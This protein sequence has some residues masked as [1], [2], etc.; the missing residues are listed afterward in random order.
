MILWKDADEYALG[1]SDK[2]RITLSAYRMVDGKAE[3]C[4][5]IVVL[6]RADALGLADLIHATVK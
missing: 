4:E 2:G 1:D 6:S 5:G 3:M